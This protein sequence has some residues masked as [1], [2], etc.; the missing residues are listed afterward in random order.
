MSTGVSPLVATHPVIVPG[1]G[2]LLKISI[3]GTFTTVGQRV[4][5]DGPTISVE[6]IDTT[7]LDSIQKTSRPGRQPEFRPPTATGLD[8]YQLAFIGGAISLAG[9][10]GLGLRGRYRERRI[11]GRTGFENRGRLSW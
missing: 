3:S 11:C 1:E 7:H 10:S 8:W 2:T 5:L 4:S 9:G 6:V